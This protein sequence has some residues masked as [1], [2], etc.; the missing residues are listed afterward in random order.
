M[1]ISETARRRTRPL[2]IGTHS[3][4]NPRTTYYGVEM[5]LSDAA[6]LFD[7]SLSWMAMVGDRESLQL[8][9]Q[10]GIDRIEK[11]NLA[12]ATRFRVGA[13]RLGVPAVDF[14]AEERS[15]IVSVLLDDPDR[16]LSRLR[17]AGVTAAK[18]AG[19]I[20]FSF[21]VFN[22]EDDVDRALAALEP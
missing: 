10:I 9:N 20:R 18:R 3:A 5:D 12:L 6:S 13:T 21:H 15:P 11:H 19:G 16:S 17:Q 22:N 8:L 4:R 7:S 2:A 14:P 1:Y